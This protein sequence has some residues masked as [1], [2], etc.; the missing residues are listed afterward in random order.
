MSHPAGGVAHVAG[1]PRDHVNVHMRHGLAGCGA[2]IKAYVVSIRLRIEAIIEQGLHPA[3][4]CYER[5][6]LR[7]RAIKERRHDPTCDHEHVAWGHG[8]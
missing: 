5:L 8:K 6:L 4:E 1:I 2:G 7:V 3:D